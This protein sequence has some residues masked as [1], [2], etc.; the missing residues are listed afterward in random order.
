M[1]KTISYSD[2]KQPKNICRLISHFRKEYAHHCVDRETADSKNACSSLHIVFPT[3]YYPHGTYS[4]VPDLFFFCLVP[5]YFVICSSQR[6]QM[7][8][9]NTVAHL[10][11]ERQ[12]L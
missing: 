11:P 9:L 7:T 8:S 6:T 5:F 2:I 3:L 12:F 1:D 10:M 4:M